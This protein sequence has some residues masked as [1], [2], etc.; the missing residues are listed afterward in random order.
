[1]CNSQPSVQYPGSRAHKP[2]AL[3]PGAHKTEAQKPGTTLADCLLATICAYICWSGVLRAVAA[4]ATSMLAKAADICRHI[5]EDTDGALLGSAVA[6][7]EQI[8]TF[9]SLL[10][11]A[12]F[13]EKDHGS[14]YASMHGA[15]NKM[16]AVA[17]NHSTT[18]LARCRGT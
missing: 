13:A 2:E 12:D 18:A 7:L 10:A 4:T 17:N 8:K 6:L 16:R 14:L 9:I 15:I 5:S 1:M 11:D 3:D